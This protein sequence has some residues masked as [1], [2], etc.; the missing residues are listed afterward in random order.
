MCRRVWSLPAAVDL[1][2]R[3]IEAFTVKC[4]D[5]RL[6]ASRLQA[7]FLMA[8]VSLTVL[9]LVTVKYAKERPHYSNIQRDPSSVRASLCRCLCRI[10]QFDAT[11]WF[12]C[13]PKAP[14]P[15]WLALELCSGDGCEG[16]WF[17]LV[18]LC[19]GLLLH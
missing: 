13:S 3:G 16:L 1:H 6:Q 15:S 12:F 10:C 14:R 18:R 17:C 19:V 5:E 4:C 2:P 9:T 11:P 7:Y 8:Y